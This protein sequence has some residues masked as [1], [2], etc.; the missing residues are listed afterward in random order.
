MDSAFTRCSRSEPI[1][2][3]QDLVLRSLGPTADYLG[4]GMSFVHDEGDSKPSPDLS[5]SLEKRLVSV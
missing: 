5:K 2:G 4:A 3:L 1:F